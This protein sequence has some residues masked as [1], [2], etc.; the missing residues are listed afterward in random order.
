MLKIAFKFTSS[1]FLLFG[2][3]SWILGGL[4]IYSLGRALVA[5][6][7]TDSDEELGERTIVVDEFSAKRAF[8]NGEINQAET[9][10]HYS[11]EDNFK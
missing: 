11:I 8:Y 2:R 7:T 5:F 4:I 1:L 3:I 9:Y 10:K 6:L